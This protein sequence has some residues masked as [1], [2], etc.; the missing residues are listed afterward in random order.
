MTLTTT[1]STDPA[2][3]RTFAA[4]AHPTRRA[5]LAQLADSGV[6]SVTQ[7]AEPHGISLM[8]ISKHIRVME[9]AGLVTHQ[10]DGRVKR[11]RLEAEPLRDALGWIQNYRRFWEAQFDSLERFL[12]ESDPQGD[13]E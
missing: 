13:E 1:T 12:E 9:R 11:C 5:I 10:R 2:L 4:L 8:A 7:L 6:A 3:D